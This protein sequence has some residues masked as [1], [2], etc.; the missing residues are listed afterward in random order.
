MNREKVI[1][2]DMQ[3]PQTQNRSIVDQIFQNPFIRDL[4]DM[5]A[6]RGMYCRFIVGEEDVYVAFG[7]DEKMV[8]GDFT[9]ARGAMI[10]E[11]V[12]KKCGYFV[13]GHD[14]PVRCLFCET[15]KLTGDTFANVDRIMDLMSWMDRFTARCMK[16]GIPTPMYGVF[17]PDDDV[18]MNF[19]ALLDNESVTNTPLRRSFDAQE[20]QYYKDRIIPEWPIHPQ[21]SR[22]GFLGFQSSRYAYKCKTVAEARALY[23]S[24]YKWKN[25]ITERDIDEYH[26]MQPWIVQTVNSNDEANFIIRG[27]QSMHI[28]CERFVINGF[29][30]K[31]RAENY[32]FRKTGLRGDAGKMVDLHLNSCDIGAFIYW[33]KQFMATQFSGAETECGTKLYYQPEKAS[34]MFCVS[35]NVLESVVGI[36]RKNKIPFGYPCDYPK[37][38]ITINQI[39]LCADIS[40]MP[41]ILPLVHRAQSEYYHTHWYGLDWDSTEE[42]RQYAKMGFPADHMRNLYITSDQPA[43]GGKKNFS[44]YVLSMDGKQSDKKITTA[45]IDPSLTPRCIPIDEA[46]EKKL[47]IVRPELRHR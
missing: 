33:Q 28:P 22:P 4:P 7:Y 40:E 21:G 44:G 10:P 15:Q 20:T 45:D 11:A 29:S 27:M 16:H 26:Y 3:K 37:N 1:L 41:R 13:P 31:M 35:S 6:L 46:V 38:L 25:H 34:Y 18:T 9:E 39:W 43:Y 32:F 5:A 42:T 47:M 30:Q 8:Y 17:D 12:V 36:L 2:Q 24:P 19:I 14:A 23:N